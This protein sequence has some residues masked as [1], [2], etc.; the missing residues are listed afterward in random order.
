MISYN[1]ALMASYRSKI[2]IAFKIIAIASMLRTSKIIAIIESLNQ[3]QRNINNTSIPNN[4][5]NKNTY[6][7]SPLHSKSYKPYSS[8]NQNLKNYHNYH[9]NNLSH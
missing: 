4:I 7:N 9:H 5:Q 2:T 8:L 1:Y 3:K 6:L